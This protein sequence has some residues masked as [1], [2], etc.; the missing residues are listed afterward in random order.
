M[1]NKTLILIALLV[2][3]IAIVM[4][5]F[6]TKPIEWTKTYNEKGKN[7]FDLKVFYEQLDSIFTKSS[8]IH[9]TFYEYHTNH[10]ELKW[11]KHNIY[12]NIDDKFIPDPSS[13]EKLLDFIALGNTAF[14]SAN[15]FSESL[16][17]E[18]NI[19]TAVETNFK[20]DSLT[21]NII[22]K[23]NHL[24]LPV[25]LKY[26]QTYFKDSINL[27]KLGQV[28]YQN[29]K[30]SIVTK[31]NFVR[32]PYLNGA[33]YLHTQPEVFTN[34]HLLKMDQ[35]DYINQ[36]LS[37]LPDLIDSENEDNSTSR[38]LFES[39]VKTDTDLVNS[40][41]RFI[42][43]HKALNFAWCLMLFTIALYLIVNSKRKQRIIPIIPKIK[44]TSLEFV[45]TIASLYEESE[46]F[47]SIIRQKINVFH[48]NIRQQYNLTTHSNHKLFTTQLSLKS[49][50]ELQKTKELIRFIN[51]I[52][53][54]N[55]S[56]ITLLKKL[57]KDI[58][59]F[60]K[61]TKKWKI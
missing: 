41:L 36:L 50:Y 60:Y 45:E 21:V 61:N 34:Y 6:N 20:Q 33:L 56:S 18:L 5:F 38:I 49:G 1:K 59:D 16:L 9:K 2:V 35:P 54:R 14:I 25:K 10:S 17:D 57:D 28:K 46:N 29:T 12:I 47:Q 3:M 4:S 24:V 30:D 27:N 53:N 31:T 26:F 42:K 44:N 8:T 7:P 52:K 15:Q 40:P 13:E 55:S 19:N 51:T 11:T 22:N 23:P 37:L 32:I 48:K 58:E 43:K 39:N